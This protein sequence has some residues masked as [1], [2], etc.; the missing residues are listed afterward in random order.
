MSISSRDKTCACMTERESSSY[1]RCTTKLGV[2][3]Q[4]GTAYVCGH[5]QGGVEM[6]ANVA[7]VGRSDVDGKRAW[8]QSTVV[9]RKKE[10]ERSRVKENS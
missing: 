1:L 5:R 8:L 2:G 3:S 7:C 6:H 10:W 4:P 9:W